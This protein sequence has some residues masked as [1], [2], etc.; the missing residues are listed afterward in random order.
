MGSVEFESSDIYGKHDIQS[1]EHIYEEEI[2]CAD[3]TSWMHRLICTL[4]LAY[5][6]N[7]F[8]TRLSHTVR[9]SFRKHIYVFV[10][11]ALLEM[12]VIC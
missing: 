8:F 12:L 3:Q 5:S 9:G 2:N 7:N 10:D 4:L 1:M 11:F 6:T